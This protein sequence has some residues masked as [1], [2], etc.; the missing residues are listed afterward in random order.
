[1]PSGTATPRVPWPTRTAPGRRKSRPIWRA[2]S[3][4]MSAARSSELPVGELHDVCEF[5][6]V[7][8]FE[9]VVIEPSRQGLDAIL[10]LTPA[11]QRRQEHRVRD[12]LAQPVREL[13]AAHVR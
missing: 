6:T 13:Q 7:G 11:G 1:M 12:A 5:L 3:C 4:W 8:G 2:S 9:D 10:D